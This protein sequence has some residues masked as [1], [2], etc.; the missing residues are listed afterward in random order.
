MTARVDMLVAC[1]RREISNPPAHIA[2]PA[3]YRNG[4][5]VVARSIAAGLGSPDLERAFL[6]KVNVEYSGTYV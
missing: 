4:V 2:D 3:S 5:A 1:I 6:R